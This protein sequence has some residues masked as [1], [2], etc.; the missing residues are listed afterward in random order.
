M[1][2]NGKKMH[3]DLA[4]GSITKDPIE[5]ERKG[6]KREEEKKGVKNG[7]NKGKLASHATRIYLGLFELGI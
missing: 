3:R 6:K 7:L 4:Q 1:G 5:Q 2:N